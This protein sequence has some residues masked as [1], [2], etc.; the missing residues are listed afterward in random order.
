MSFHFSSPRL[1][2]RP[3]RDTDRPAL[4]QMATDAG[5]MRHIGDGSL[6]SEARI[7][8]FLARQQRHLERHGVCFGAA[9]LAESDRVVGLA[10]MQMLDTGDFELGWWIW[11]DYHGRGLAVEAVQP[12]IR[13]ARDVMQLNRLVAVID[14]P[15]SASIRVA[16][17]LGMRFERRM[18]A[19]ETI[20]SRD[21]S[22]IALYALNNL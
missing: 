18:R 16:E 13:H 8:D 11:K 7:D 14:P 3:W 19:S 20:A 15:N 5:M 9:A 10:G 17:K 21:D 4:Q 1:V 22:L 12:F 2:I 6:W